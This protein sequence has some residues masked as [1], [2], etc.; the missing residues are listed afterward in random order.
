MLQQLSFENKNCRM[1]L[2]DGEPWFVAK[3][4]CE[5][6]GLNNSRMAVDR[7]DENMKGVSSI[8]TLG[9][10]QDMTIVNEA[11][12]YRLTFSSRKAEAE[13][14]TTWV[15]SEVLPSIRKTGTY[16]PAS[17]NADF[18]LRLGQAMKEKELELQAKEKQILKLAPKAEFYDD[19]AKSDTL[20][21]MD[22]V[23]KTLGYMGRNKL[24][25][26]LR[27]KKV[28][29]RNNI[30]YQSFV[31]QKLFQLR[32]GKYANKDEKTGIYTQTMVTGKGLDFIRKTLKKETQA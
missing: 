20:L 28:L 10:T 2:K 7:L 3:D 24:F 30:P 6:L 8:D 27:D 32:V 26:E 22:Q 31:D 16:L 21:T 13:R 9:G 12:L 19:V 17:I 5:I 15:V 11:G 1:V 18:V 4:V 14:F 23:A 29:M 25:Q